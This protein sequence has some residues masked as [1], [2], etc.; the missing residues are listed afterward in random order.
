MAAVKKEEKIESPICALSLVTPSLK[1]TR[2]E[3]VSCVLRS[4]GNRATSTS[5]AD[6]QSNLRTVLPPQQQPTRKQRR[7][8]SPELHRRFE[9]ALQQLGGSQGEN[10]TLDH[11]KDLSCFTCLKQLQVFC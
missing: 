6:I 2:E 11:E 5:A 1:N 7:C 9:N 8:W 4:S 3:L 10:Y